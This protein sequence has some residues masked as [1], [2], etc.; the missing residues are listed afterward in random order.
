[1]EVSGYNAPSYQWQISRDS[2][3][4]WND[5]PG[6]TGLSLQVRPAGL[7]NYQY[8]L[9]VVERENATLRLCRIS[10]NSLVIGVHPLPEVKAGPDRMLVK[11]A[12]A[13]LA[14][15]VKGSGMTYTWTP[16]LYLSDPNNLNPQV[17]A[18]E[19]IIYTLTAQSSYGCTNKDEAWVK[20]A[21]DLYIPN[22]FTPNGD[23]VNDIWR[24]P[25]LDPFLEAKVSIYNRYGQRVYYSQGTIV[26]WDGTYQNKTLPAEVYIYVI[27][28]TKAKRI[29]NGIVT[30][31]R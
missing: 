31:V 10:S 20:V 6:A 13:T 1:M 24:I 23:G 29:L 5:I 2:G 12:T 16:V 28:L 30:I 9:S 19:D 11:G 3:A 27:D 21:N 4:A 22:A 8:R 7:D 17:S 14:G 18:T 25:F 26:F 15:E